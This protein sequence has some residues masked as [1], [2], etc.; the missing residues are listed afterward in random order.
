MSLFQ[1]A[2][3]HADPQDIM[4]GVRMVL[5]STVDTA[6]RVLTFGPEI[7]TRPG[8]SESR[9]AGRIFRPRLLVS[10]PAQPCRP[11]AWRFGNR[12]KFGSDAIR[13]HGYAPRQLV[14]GRISMIKCSE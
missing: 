8:R 14:P 2:C 6:I 1:F 7:R 9:A 12:M 10:Y 13:S 11:S 5:D 3:Q 4:I